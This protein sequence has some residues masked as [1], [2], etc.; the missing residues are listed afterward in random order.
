VKHIVFSSVAGSED[1][2]VEHFYSKFRIETIIHESGISSAVVRP[3][4]F[5]EVIPPAGLA[6]NFMLST[7]EAVFG[8][9]QQK[10]IACEDIGKT[11][12]RALL[13]PDQFSGK[14]LTVCGD[15]KTIEEVNSDYVLLNHG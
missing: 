12:A 9:T 2:S 1:K 4:G 11:V 6:R 10:W 13:Q 5:M 14:V 3:V 15:V 7:M 8:E